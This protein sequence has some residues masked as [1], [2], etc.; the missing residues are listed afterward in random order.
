MDIHVMG[1][2]GVLVL[3]IIGMTQPFMLYFAPGFLVKSSRDIDVSIPALWTEK[4][5][6]IL[7]YFFVAVPILL[8]LPGKLCFM[9]LQVLLLPETFNIYTESTTLYLGSTSLSLSSLSD[10]IPLSVFAFVLFRAP[11][12]SF[13]KA[14]L[15]SI[16][17]L[18]VISISMGI[19]VFIIGVNDGLHGS[20]NISENSGEDFVK[21]IVLRYDWFYSIFCG[22]IS[23]LFIVLTARSFKK[24][25]L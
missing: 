8:Y 19:A 14:A 6:F 13:G 20:L 16:I 18:V 21:D 1:V 15:F 22:L 4:A 2:M 12:P 17:S 9:L 7:L 11:K 5:T 3:G 10:I 24:I 23:A 25:Q